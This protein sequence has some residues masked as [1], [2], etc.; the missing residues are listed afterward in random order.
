MAEQALTCALRCALVACGV[1]GSVIAAR[2]DLARPGRLVVLRAGQ[3]STSAVDLGG[4]ERDGRVPLQLAP[5]RHAVARRLALPGRH[6]SAPVAWAGGIVVGTSNGLWLGGG[7][8]APR[9]LELGPIDARPVVL[10][11]GELLVAARDGRLLVLDAL[12]RVTR[13]AR[14]SASIRTSPLVLEDGSI[15]VT[16][17]DRSV[18]RYDAALEP[19]FSVT[20]PAG[21]VHAA[22]RLSSERVVVAAGERL[23]VLDLAGSIL[24]TIDL[25][26]RA[27]APPVVDAAGD[28][29]VLLAQGVIAVVSQGAFVRARLP[30]G[31]RVL[32]QSAMLALA[33]DGSYRVAVPAMGVVAFDATGAIRWQ[34]ST[35][36]PF[37]GPIAI[38]GGGL[39]L[40][41]DRRGRL[42]VLSPSGELL[43]R[44]ELG[45]LAQGYPLLADDGSVWVTTDAPEVVQIA[46]AAR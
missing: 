34:A 11:S 21:L 17:L 31:A 14:I 1:L 41:F 22:A 36:A 19:V 7:P 8:L 16:A 37:H 13:S 24:R 43:E 38:D 39:T 25:E 4:P 26:D 32:D 33:E 12:T 6:A 40:A 18:A 23:H 15:V 44:L 20:L 45:G 46:H 2:A 42:A 9:V 3:A 27:V 28:V 30:L 5:G 35:D 29:H 10:P